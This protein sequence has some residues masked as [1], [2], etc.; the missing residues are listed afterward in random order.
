MWCLAA[1]FYFT[2]QD[3]KVTSA[4]EALSY[5]KSFGTMF[6]ES[7]MSVSAFRSLHNHRCK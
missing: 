1:K 5:I 3:D 4:L 7:Q 6:S 2:S